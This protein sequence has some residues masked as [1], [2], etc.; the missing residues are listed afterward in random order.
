MIWS[1][2]HREAVARLRA[3]GIEGAE[4]D[5]Q[6]LADHVLGGAGRWRLRQGEAADSADRAAYDAAIAARAARQPVSQITGSRAFWKHDFR[7]TPDTLD[8]RPDTETL[9]EAALALPWNSVLDLGTG[10]GA[11]LISLLSDRSGATGTGAD[12]SAAAL[13]VARGNAARIGVTADFRQADW[14]AG[15]DGRFD[16]I[17]SNPPY[18][19]LAEMADLAPEVRDWEPHQALTDFGD[20]LAAYRAIAAGARDHL[21]PGGRVLVEIGPTQAVA[22]AALFVAAGAGATRVLP[23][24][25]GRDRVIFA[26]FPAI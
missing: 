19:A 7:V 8:P 21:T 9:V 15:I 20:G 13:E 23:D 17:V 11:I 1:A 4:R 6:R 2:L 24:L 14:Y 18:I 5:A 26:Q 12:I 25:D 16:L 22:V 3:A 10:T